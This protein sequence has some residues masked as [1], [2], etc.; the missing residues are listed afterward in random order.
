MSYRVTVYAAEAVRE[1]RA[2]SKTE[3]VKIAQAAAADARSAAPVQTGEYRDG[4]GVDQSGDQVAIVDTDPE[5]FYKEY[6]TS[7]TPAHAT[8][9][10]AARQYGKYSGMRP[11]RG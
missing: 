3:R 4:I 7:D 5:A 9:T 8:L 1:A 11:R 2:L 10:N 6:G